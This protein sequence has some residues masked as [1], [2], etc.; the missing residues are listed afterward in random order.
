MT[1]FVIADLHFGDHATCTRFRRPDGSLLRPFASAREMDGEIVRRWNETVSDRDTVYVLGDIGRG[2]N[3]LTVRDLTGV[4]HLIGGNGDDLSAIIGWGIFESVRVVKYLPGLL[5]T[6]I[7]V[8]PSQ[9]ARRTINVHGHLHAQSL[10]DPRYRCVSVEQTDFRPV[11]IDGL[12]RSIEVAD[13]NK[14][15]RLL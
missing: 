5:L 14:P 9:L 3:A 13:E 2:R 8:H 1:D 12:S 15:P 11:E 4:K 7:P 6:H 10:G